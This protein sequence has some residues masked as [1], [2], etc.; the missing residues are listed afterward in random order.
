MTFAKYHV[1]SH[2]FIKILHSS[3]YF[4]RILIWHSFRVNLVHKIVLDPFQSEM[5]INY[6]N[7]LDFSC[8]M[9][10]SGEEN[11]HG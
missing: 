9:T 10:F 11:R 1:C 8:L 5:I 3:Y 6:S 2:V 7:F 4:T